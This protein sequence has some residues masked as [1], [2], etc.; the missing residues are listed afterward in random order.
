MESCSKEIGKFFNFDVE[1]NLKKLEGGL[2]NKTFLIDKGDKKL[3]SNFFAFT[4]FTNSPSFS[5][6]HTINNKAPT[7]T[8]IKPKIELSNAFS[9][10]KS[11]NA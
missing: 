1:S 2:V 11:S 5:F 7:I 6:L 3:V 10:Y 9:A 8:K 4:I